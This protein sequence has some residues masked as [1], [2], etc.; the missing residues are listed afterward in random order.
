M[1]FTLSDGPEWNSLLP[2]TFTRPTAEIRIGILTLREKWERLL[3]T[4]TYTVTQAHLAKKYTPYPEKGLHI[5]INPIFLPTD[6]LIRA[7][8]EL[9]ENQALMKSGKCIAFCHESQKVS[10]TTPT[11]EIPYLQDLIRIEY[12]W[13]IFRHNAIALEQD[14]KLLT[15]NRISAPLSK[16]NRITGK[17]IFIEQGAIVEHATLNTQTGPIYIGKDAKI[18]EGCLIRGGLALCEGAILNMGTKIYGATTIGPH[19]KVGGE[20]NNCVFFAYSNKSHE[21]FLGNS[22]LVEWCNLGA[23][24]NVS[25]LKNNYSEIDVWSYATHQTVPT[26]LQFCGLLMG[27]HS[28]SAVNTKFNTG[29]VVG[30]FCNVFGYGFPPRHIPSFSWGG[31]QENK[32]F[33][34]EKA[35]KA[36]QVMMSRRG[37]SFDSLDREILRYIFDLRRKKDNTTS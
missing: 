33:D 15:R 19:C 23:G 16:S 17:N 21:G 31:I 24:T 3:K 10:Y 36:A 14:F 1:Q 20:I 29:T 25:N 22:V 28:K 4:N 35:C 2:L 8:H 13:D 11:K 18:M 32:I 12:P 7:I 30:V 27:D 9:K 6:D 37:Q 5:S 26:G 34:F